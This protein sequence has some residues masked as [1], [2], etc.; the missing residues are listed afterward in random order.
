MKKN[1][2]LII[3]LLFVFLGVLLVLYFTFNKKEGKRYRWVEDYKT[4]NE[5][6]YGTLFIQKLL[7]SYRPGQE[8][9]LNDKMPLHKLLDTAK[10][11]PGT[12][13]V[14]VGYNIYLD[15]ADKN[16]LLNFIHSGN[17]AFI[18]TNYLPFAVI[19]PIFVAECDQEIFLTTKDTIAATLNFY[20]ENL[21][22]DKGYTYSY[23]FGKTDLP[24]FWNYLNGYIFCD[25]TRS[26]T[27]LGYIHPDGV[28]FFRLSYGKGNLYVHTNPLAFT[29]YFLIKPEKMEYAASVFSHLRG[30]SIIWDEFSK[31]NFLPQNNAPEISPIAYILQQ[32]SL[33]YAWWLMLAGAIL[34]TLFTAKRK[35]RV[36]PV[37]EEKTNTSLEF[38]NMI[39]S[40]HFQNQNHRDIALKK[41]KY[42]M[43]FIRVKYGIHAQNL[44]E[45]HLKRLAEKSKT[46][47]GDLQLILNEFNY[48]EH[49]Q[50]YY[51]QLRLI[52]LYNALDKFYKHCK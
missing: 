12:D 48:V 17:D 32:D 4:T 51:N 33:K 44:T 19:D 29:N 40:L 1:S 14:F 13:Y 25:S 27:P 43:Y 52:D 20:N 16:A 2:N 8:F 45:A 7:A 15:D 47:L 22:T 49:Q 41:V 9:I 24:Y 42:F 38:V 5:Q 31:A 34:Y 30:N 28:N 6:P 10:T 39:S 26:I 21:K 11:K 18:A 3:K 46:E 23:R 50:Y 37:L 36:V 35:Q